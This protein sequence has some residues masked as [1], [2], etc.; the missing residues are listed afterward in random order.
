MTYLESSI[1]DTINGIQFSDIFNIEEIQRLQDLFSD[2]T[3]V[4]SIIS[5]PDGKP[6]TRSSNFCHLCSNIIRKTEKGNAHCIKS[7]EAIGR[8]NPS[9]PVVQMCQC[10]GLWDACASITVGGKH[11]ANWLIG[12]VRNEE[13]DEQRMLEYAGEI[14]ADKE[15]FMEALSEVPVMSVKQFNKVSEMLFAYANELSEKAHSNLQLKLQ[16]AERENAVRLLQESE[17][18]F[19][20]TLHSIGDA[21]LSTDRNGLIVNINPKAE[22]LCGWTKADARGKSLN[23]VFTIINSDTREVVADP[24]KKV[25]ESGQIIDLA[26]HTLLISKKGTEYQIANS[27]APIKNKDGDINGVVLVFS[28]VTEKYKTEKA[29]RESERS[30]SV[31]LS[32]LPGMAYRCRFD[33]EWTMEFV[34]EGCY[35]LTG[36]KGEDIL[37]NRTLSFNDLILPEYREHLWQVWEKAVQ[38]HGI[39]CEEYQILTADKKVKWVWE[40]G[41]PIYNEAGE[42][43][44]LEGLILDITGRKQAEEELEHEQYLMHS[45]MEN[46]PDHIYFKDFESRFIRINNAHARSFGMSDPGEAVGKTDF[47]FFTD[48]HAQQAYTDEQEI[49]RTGQPI[50][51]EEKQTWPDLRDTWVSTTKLPLRDKDEKII[52]TFGISVDITKR[53]QAE[54]T[55]HNE[56]LLLRTIIDNIP[57]AIYTKDI[58]GCKT[59]ANF[60]EV[61]YLGAT[62]EADVIGKS[63]FEFY[64]KELAEYFSVDDKLILTNGTPVIDREDYIFDANNQKRWLLSSKLPLRDRNN[65]IIGLVG[66]GHDITDYKKAQ[67]ALQESETL[68]RNL[69]EKLPDGVYTST[70]AG[71][72]VDL[73]PAMVKILGYDSKEELMPVNIRTQLYYDPVDRDNIVL[74]GKQVMMNVFRLK[75]K[76]G[77]VIWV[78]D[79]VW[80]NENENP[81]SIFYEGIIRD[82]TERKQAELA[83]QESESLYRNL[84]ERLPDGIYK[85]TREGKFVDVNP[86]MITMLGYDSKE[87]LMDIDIKTQLYFEPSDRENQVLNEKD[88]NIGVYRLKKKDGSEFWVEDKVR[89]SLNEKGEILFHEGIIRDITERKL[90]EL[91]L[92]ESESLYRNLVERL[93]DGVYKSTHEGKFVD[94]NPA[95]VKILGYESKE[96]LMGINIKTQLYFESTERQSDVVNE[97]LETIGVYRMKKKDG[98]EIWVE[99]HGW[100]SRDEDVNILYHEGIMWDITERK[101]AELAL[102]E[103]ESLYRNL[104]E[105]LPDGV[106]KSTHEGKFV[107]VNPAMV[108]MLG[109]ESKDELMAIDI[110]TQ[111]YFKPSDR[112]SLVL[113]EKLEE[114]GIYRL[115]KKDGS[116]IWVEDHGWYNMDEHGKIL[117]HEGIMRDITE[118]KLAEDALKESEEQNRT[119]LQTAMDGFWLVNRQG[120]LLE[121]NEAY[122]QMSGYSAPEL[123]SMRISDLEAIESGDETRDHIQKIIEQGETRFESRHLRKD[124]SLF[125]VEV[126][127]KYQPARGGQLMVF[128]HDITNRKLKEQELIKAKEKAEESDR[129][130]SAFLANMSHEIR[131]P[132]NGILGF[133]DLLKTPDLSGEEQQE[134]IRIIKK[135]GE[136]MLNI[137][138]DIVD[139]SKIESGQM[140]VNLSETKI[141]GQTEFLYTFFKPEVD[142]KGIK[143]TMKNGLSEKESI[144]K[145][146]KEKVY[147]ILTNLVKNAIKFTSKGSIEFGY[148]LIAGQ[149]AA[150]LLKFYVKD[151]GFGIPA[152][153]QQAIFDRF[154][155]ADIADSM[156]FQGAGL[157]LSISKAFVEMLGGTIWVESQEGK[158]SSFYFTLPYNVESKQVPSVNPVPKNEKDQIKKLKIL[159]AEDDETSEI[160][161]SMA[162]RMFGKEILNVRTGVDAVEACR[163]NPDI[164]LILMDV[165]MPVMDGYEATRQIRR[166]NNKVFILAQTAFGLVEEKEKAIEAGCDEYISKPLDIASLRN[167]IRNKFKI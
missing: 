101:L 162:I 122:S 46:V 97:D 167:L 28:D 109:Y 64:P 41:T 15:D 131:T 100:F 38:V 53:K 27:A 140:K 124:G 29:L 126:S 107:D 35:T 13:T 83:L 49:I 142:K 11:I 54:E 161:M 61:R 82:V 110:K 67:L 16:I 98:S 58:N 36:Y 65:Q 24:V 71:K 51:K 19:S 14:G 73:N 60:T 155:Q 30:K 153:R 106:Y 74:Q 102:Q 21:V 25:L 4:S 70:Y 85:S 59:L 134:Y 37:Q 76:D 141:N 93:P 31:L 105:R 23:E 18:N 34:S 39:I 17:E 2:A 47:D 42:V 135:S 103:S 69:V 50:S 88:E 72:F 120:Q 56:R 10:G 163:N 151:T 123:L 91:A 156:A 121:V 144:I 125:D 90:A 157:G 139:I 43:E 150:P 130:K 99:D 158:G 84:M 133:A 147:A 149:H 128:L 132:M 75:K 113:Q 127:V 45:L 152:N 6:I 63:D 3:G 94:I 79:H 143:L 48:E 165:K 138:N 33:P 81:D 104:V 96:E 87:E 7:G 57:D 129:L 95:M 20:T 40:Q 119:I 111:L 62:S 32:N 108:K 160:L 115:K 145:T 22:I 8:F 68:Y 52:G 116:E 26:N 118:R 89:Y 114:M 136:R 137:I 112:E 78:E 66:I 86:A 80:Q 44:A 55:I 166:F 5:H 12:Q 154:I 77:S 92:Q 159:I 9:G 148:T 146:D 1:H 164:D 117:F